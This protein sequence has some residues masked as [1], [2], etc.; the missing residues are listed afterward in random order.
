MLFHS[1]NYHFIGYEIFLSCCSIACLNIVLFWLFRQ[2][3]IFH[4]FSK[5]IQN[6]AWRF[7]F[8]FKLLHWDRSGITFGYE[9]FYYSTNILPNCFSDNIATVDS[10]IHCVCQCWYINPPQ[11]CF[12]LKWE[13]NKC[14]QNKSLLCCYQH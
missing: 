7:F 12:E 4:Y 6:C 13:I 3:L 2:T 8:F 11:L 14:T 5:D 9:H 1:H 10:V